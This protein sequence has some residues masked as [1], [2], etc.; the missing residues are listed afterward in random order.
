MA[1]LWPPRIPGA[2]QNVV[3]LG[4]SSRKAAVIEELEPL[5][6][7]PGLT[8]ER[9]PAPWRSS[10]APSAARDCPSRR[11]GARLARAKPGL[12]ADVVVHPDRALLGH[13]E[14]NP[15]RLADPARRVQNLEGH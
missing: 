7:S 6:R 2:R 14:I 8:D 11:R 9:G 4:V 5:P 15:L 3:R 12:T 10:P 13:L 1:F